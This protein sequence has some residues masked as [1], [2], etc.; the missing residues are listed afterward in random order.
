M[1]PDPPPPI[2]FHVGKGYAL[3]E[4]PSGDNAPHRHA[5]FQVAIAPQGE[6]AISDGTQL[7]AAPVLVVPP[8]LRHQ[9]Q[10]IARLRNYF[11]EPHCR[12]A[13]LLREGCGSGITAMP[14]LH[15]LR[16]EQVR[17]LGAS[18]SLSVDARLQQVMNALSMPGDRSMPELARQAG[19]SPQRLRALAQEQLGMPLARWR[20][21][22]RFGLAAKA[23]STGG[24]LADAAL[25]AGFADQAHLSRQ[26]REMFGVPPSQLLPLL[27]SQVF[28]AT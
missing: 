28:S 9:M 25:A 4:G 11:I 13:D 15:D 8:L 18:A 19:L 17:S 27:R 6:V 7:H 3:F 5:A 23:V 14:Q 22:Q 16:E 12:F 1:H 24:G 2:R 20:I 21:W 10:P 26:M